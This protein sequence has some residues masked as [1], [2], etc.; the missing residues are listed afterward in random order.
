MGDRGLVAVVFGAA[1]GGKSYDRD[2]AVV[3]VFPGAA[4]GSNCGSGVTATD[5]AFA[6]VAVQ[7]IGRVFWVFAVVVNGDDRW[8]VCGGVVTR[9]G[10]CGDLSVDG[11]E[12]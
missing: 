9:G 7:C 1:P 12:H 8:G 3:L 11:G 4:G 6:A 10:F 2:W 5:E